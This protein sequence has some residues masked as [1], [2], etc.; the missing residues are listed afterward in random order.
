MGLVS[1][2]LV[3]RGLYNTTLIWHIQYTIKIY[4]QGSEAVNAGFYIYKTV[5]LMLDRNI[6]FL[7]LF[8]RKKK[9]QTRLLCCCKFTGLVPLSA[10]LFVQWPFFVLHPKQAALLRSCCSTRSIH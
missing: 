1:Y 2:K 8:A 7:N 3:N 6:V 10:A 9:N 5:L 4:D